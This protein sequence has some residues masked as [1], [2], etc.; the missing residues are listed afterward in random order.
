MGGAHNHFIDH[1]HGDSGAGEAV[2]GHLALA[3]GAADGDPLIG[4]E[5]SVLVG[6]IVELALGD[7]HQEDGL[8]MLDD[9][10]GQDGAF[11]IQDHHGVDR[12]SGVGRGLNEIQ[13]LVGI[14]FQFVSGIELL[15]RAVT[16]SRYQ[17][18]Y[19]WQGFLDHLPAGHGLI[20]A[21]RQGLSRCTDKG[22]KE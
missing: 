15:Y 5:A 22:E 3:G 20:L 16:F 19:R 1:H 8:V 11:G 14:A 18:G 4:L 17:F 12:L 21:H 7:A 13:G 10:G 6:E 9:L 2:H